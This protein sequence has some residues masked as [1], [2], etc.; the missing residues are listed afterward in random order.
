MYEQSNSIM[1]IKS[2]TDLL[3]AYD[4]YFGHPNMKLVFDMHSNE[5]VSNIRFTG[6]SI[7]NIAIEKGKHVIMMKSLPN[8]I[9]WSQLKYMEIARD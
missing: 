7:K 6:M 3:L 4:T 9:R 5:I 2:K 8:D 1:T